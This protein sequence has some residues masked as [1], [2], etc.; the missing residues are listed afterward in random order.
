MI[1]I[2]NLLLIAFVILSVISCSQKGDIEPG[3]ALNKGVVTM[4]SVLEAEYSFKVLPNSKI[5]NY[6]G[7]VFVHFLDPDNNIVFTD[8][9]NPPKPTSQWKAGENYSYKRNIYIPSDILSGEYKIRLGIYDPAGKRDRV[10]LRAREI[11]D[12]SYELAKLT[13]K[14]PLWDLI[15]YEEGWYEVEHSAEDP[16]IQWRWTKGKAIAYL[17][18]PLKDTKLHISYEGNPEYA[19]DKKIKVI[20]KIN[21]NEI[22][23]SYIEDNK[24]IDKII[25]IAKDLAKDDRYIKFEIDVSSVFIPKDVGHS[26]DTREL[27]IKIYRLII[28]DW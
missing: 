28:E 15:K 20:F 24:K 21:D 8:D 7:I 13:I 11:K 16:F 26:D 14:A 19:P 5:P 12:R 23:E 17:L 22:E 2:C 27:G 10:P 4:G 18:N 9:H 25:S 3:I 6:D 1:R